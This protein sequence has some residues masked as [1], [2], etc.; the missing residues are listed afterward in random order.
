MSPLLR[1]VKEL[2]ERNLDAVEIAHR[3]HVSIEH[4]NQTIECLIKI[5]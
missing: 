1:Q 5:C 4:V 2:L 3:L